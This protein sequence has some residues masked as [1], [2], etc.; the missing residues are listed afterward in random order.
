MVNVLRRFKRSLAV[1]DIWW[2]RD[3][4]TGTKHKN[5]LVIDHPSLIVRGP[6]GTG[7]EVL[8]TVGS[9]QAS[10]NPSNPEIVVDPS[11]GAGLDM[12][13]VSNRPLQDKTHF[14]L[15]L[16]EVK[17]PSI[18]RTFAGAL[19]PDMLEILRQNR[20]SHPVRLPSTPPI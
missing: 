6:S 5:Q 2:A 3:S 1:G 20:P 15:I 8:A 7:G 17:D 14:W 9:K 13:I 4:D 12:T 16:S 10:T 19:S 11:T 18:Y